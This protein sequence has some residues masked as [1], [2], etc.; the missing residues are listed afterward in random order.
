MKTMAML[1][2]AAAVLLFA[3]A[4]VA[5]DIPPPPRDA[6]GNVIP[7][8]PPDP[9]QVNRWRERAVT[10]ASRS[11]VGTVIA[12]R[13]TSGE[14]I[15]GDPFV[16]DYDV[17]LSWVFRIDYA[18][19]GMD[20]GVT[21]FEEPYAESSCGS[22]FSFGSRYIYSDGG[23]DSVFLP[24]EP[25]PDELAHWRTIA[26]ADPAPEPE[27]PAAPDPG[28]LTPPEDILDA[29]GRTRPT[30][31]PIRAYIAR[32]LGYRLDDTTLTADM[33]PCADPAAAACAAFERRITSIVV[34]I[35]AVVTGD[36]SALGHREFIHPWSYFEA[37]PMPEP[38]QLYLLGVGRY[39]PAH[40]AEPR[41]LLA[42]PPDAAQLAQWRAAGRV[43]GGIE[44]T[45]G[46][47]ATRL[48]L[49]LEPPESPTDRNGP[50]LRISNDGDP[51]IV[52]GI[53]INRGAACLML[54]YRYL[55]D[56][57]PGAG[58][59]YIAVIPAHVA[60]FN[61]LP[62]APRT[63]FALLGE[64]EAVTLP[65]GGTVDVI[66]HDEHAPGCGALEELVLHTS[67]GDLRITG[68]L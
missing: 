52:T 57:D 14:L 55:R 46:A 8:P 21:L 64:A 66:V 28:C 63:D 49:E 16:S 65:T 29:L 6:N 18:I 35:E 10:A 53:V 68:F 39:E 31:Q 22:Y 19:E 11:F 4:A 25:T 48:R 62:Y 13:T 20:P 3:P 43:R 47:V 9:V 42:T 23:W 27:P 7:P 15:A 36:P 44:M 67:Q 17:L 24:E 34:D 5:C 37:C 33:S 56:D 60:E 41:V 12:Y 45:D 32:V 54:L 59:R 1:T 38:G 58:P 50:T 30:E 51:I 26:A 40:A 2:A 61:R